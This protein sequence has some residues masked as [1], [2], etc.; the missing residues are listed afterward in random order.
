MCRLSRCSGARNKLHASLVQAKLACLSKAQ[1]CVNGARLR[2]AKEWKEK[3]VKKE[4][5]V[6]I[7]W[8]T[9]AGKCDKEGRLSEDDVTIGVL[10]DHYDPWIT[11]MLGSSCFTPIRQGLQ[12]S[13]FK[14]SYLFEK[15]K[16]YKKQSTLLVYRTLFGASE[17]CGSIHIYG[18]LT[19][20][21]DDSVLLD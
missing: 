11:A 12:E 15:K 17:C 9:E 4:P 7:I 19:S 13:T 18:I 10:N 6:S 20:T 3:V 16:R 1:A 2:T 14:R 5:L 8:G 21:R